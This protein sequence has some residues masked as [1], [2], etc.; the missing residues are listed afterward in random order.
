MEPKQ[1]RVCLVSTFYSMELYDERGDE[2][3]DLGDA[4]RVAEELYGESWKEVYN[5]QFGLSRD[6]WGELVK[7]NAHVVREV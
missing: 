1:F 5:G 4:C 6:E 7:E 3:Y 2:V